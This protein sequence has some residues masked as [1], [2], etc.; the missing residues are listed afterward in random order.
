M[1]IRMS[2]LASVL[3]V[4]AMAAPSWAKGLST[5]FFSSKPMNI[6]TTQIKPGRYRFVVSGSTGKVNVLRHGKIVAKVDGKWVNLKHK[7]P[8]NEVLSTRNNI[9]ELCFA[10]KTRA[11]KFHA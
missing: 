2:F 7:S 10:G 3:C 6:G 9:Q 11:I 5:R 8:Y 4:L 1:R